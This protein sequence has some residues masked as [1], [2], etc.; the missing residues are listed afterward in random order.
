MK[1]HAAK[2][3]ARLAML[4]VLLVAPAATPAAAQERPG[5]VA[6]LAA[7]A[8]VFPDDGAVTEGFAGGTV[9]FHVSPRISVGPEVAFISG[10]SHSHLMLTGNVTFDF[11]GPVNGR[12]PA[13]TPFVVAGGGLFRTNEEFL[14]DDFS[15]SDGA[16]TAGGGVRGRVG[17]RVIVG[18]EARVGWELHLRFNVLVGVRLGR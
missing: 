10:E 16:F 14:G 12:A 6:E 5:P 8:L 1:L 3:Q 11:L 17:D 7:G 15:S 18:A 4:A 2:R 9:R 13:L